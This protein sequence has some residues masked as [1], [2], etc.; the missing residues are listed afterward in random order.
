MKLFI[1]LLIWTILYCV[2]LYFE[3]EPYWAVVAGWLLGLLCGK[4]LLR[5]YIDDN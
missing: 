2:V 1:T 5:D 3:M 4:T